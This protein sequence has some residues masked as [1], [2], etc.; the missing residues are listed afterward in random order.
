MSLS[1]DSYLRHILDE[2]K[3]VMSVTAETSY[4]QFLADETL[5]R[6][7]VRSLEIMGEAAKQIPDELREKQPHIAWKL[8]GRMRDKLIHAYFSID[9]VIVWDTVQREVPELAEAV[10]ALLDEIEKERGEGIDEE[11]SD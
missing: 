9:Y 4:R 11:G 7:V 2:T 10:T 6:A 8:I 5:K 1:P 3:Y